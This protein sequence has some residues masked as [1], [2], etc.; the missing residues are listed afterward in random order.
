[1]D[2]VARSRAVTEMVGGLTGMRVAAGPAG[3]EMAGVTAESRRAVDGT[4]TIVAS[5]AETAAA[6]GSGP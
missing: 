1:M 6:P 2:L 3:M 5:V 4:A